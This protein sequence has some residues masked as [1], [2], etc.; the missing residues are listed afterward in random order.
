MAATFPFHRVYKLTF[1]GRV[2]FTMFIDGRETALTAVEAE[3][4]E[5]AGASIITTQTES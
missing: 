5:A 3:R 2:F 4:M 1:A